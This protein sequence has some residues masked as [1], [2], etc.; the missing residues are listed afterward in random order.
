MD[1]IAMGTGSQKSTL[2]ARLF[3]IEE[4]SE[5]WGVSSRQV[6]RW[7]ARRELPVFRLGGVVR[8]DERDLQQFYDRH[9]SQD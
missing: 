9:R 1:G 6:R 4:I 8:I 3:T 2:P 7:I 5:I